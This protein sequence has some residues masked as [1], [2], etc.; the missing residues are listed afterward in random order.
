MEPIFEADFLDSSTGFRGGIGQLTALTAVRNYAIKGF[1]FV[2]DADIEGFFDNLDHDKLMAA[3]RRRISDPALLR[4]IWRWLKAGVVIAGVRKDTDRGTPQGGV[5]SP[6][7]ANVYL[8]SFD[9]AHKEQRNFISRLTRFADD[10]V[11][12]CGTRRHAE[13]AV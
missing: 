8:H 3:L 10:F 12:Q 13:Q 2:V 9:K 6:L 4:L 7:L 11:L 5:I 1:R